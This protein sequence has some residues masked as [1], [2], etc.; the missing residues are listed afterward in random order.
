[1]LTSSQYKF[2]NIRSEGQEIVRWRLQAK[3]LR[4]FRLDFSAKA[5]AA[6]S[7]SLP[8]RTPDLINT[9]PPSTAANR[10][11]A[12][13]TQ[14]MPV[15]S[16]KAEDQRNLESRINGVIFVVMGILH[17]AEAS[18]DANTRKRAA[19]DFDAVARHLREGPFVQSLL[20]VESAHRV[21]DELFLSDIGRGRVERALAIM[22][23]GGD[24]EGDGTERDV[25]AMH[26]PTKPATGHNTRT[27]AASGKEHSPSMSLPSCNHT[28]L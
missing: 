22:G 15:S 27:T 20:G 26:I 19:E 21:D 28:R 10:K 25:A 12:T 16:T 9:A 13:P 1:M 3:S 18:E 4:I 6:V 24:A 14:L 5:S 11:I 17:A 23:A 2:V 8:I 7:A